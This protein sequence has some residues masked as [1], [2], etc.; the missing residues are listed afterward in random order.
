MI[1]NRP[2]TSSHFA[3]WAK[4]PG[5]WQQL[6]EGPDRAEVLARL[7]DL[8]GAAALLVLPVGEVPGAD[9]PGQL[10]RGLDAEA[11]RLP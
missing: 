5:G 2:K 3:G 11:S 10:R 7:L 8:A 1:R 4:L 6:C 9:T